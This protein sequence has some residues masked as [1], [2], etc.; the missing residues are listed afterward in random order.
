MVPGRSASVAHGKR[1]RAA[2]PR[3]G[4]IVVIVRRTVSDE[5]RPRS[6]AAARL[7]AAAHAA[8]AP[9]AQGA[10][11]APGGP[12]V[13]VV[14][15]PGRDVSRCVTGRVRHAGAREAARRHCDGS[16]GDSDDAPRAE[17]RATLLS[18]DR[19][20]LDELLGGEG[21]DASTLAM[22]E[23]I[24]ARRRGTAPGTRARTAD[25]LAAL[26]DRA[27]D[28]SVDEVQARIA[29]PD[30]GL[31]GD[32]FAELLERGRAIALDVPTVSGA[33]R[34]VILTETYAR[35]AAAFPASVIPSASV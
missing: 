21:A 17:Q 33:A 23:S 4:W 8:L 18:L 6:L 5:R 7:T 3:R 9:T 14:S 19:A 22:L 10:R 35:Y 16:R 12:G 20:L 1:R 27:G 34:R 13:S 28:L 11:S 25:E 15:D 2:R 24:L 30:E 26:I 32:P 31:R 29:S